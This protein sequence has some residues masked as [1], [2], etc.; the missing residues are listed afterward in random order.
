MSTHGDFDAEDLP[1]GGFGPEDMPGVYRAQY[2]WVIESALAEFPLSGDV[3]AFVKRLWEGLAKVMGWQVPPWP[4]DVPLPW[5]AASRTR[6]YVDLR[7]V[8]VPHKPN[9]GPSSSPR[10]PP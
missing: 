3:D 5:F 7:D 1:D 8:E 9:A 6:A 10:P 4:E 2:E